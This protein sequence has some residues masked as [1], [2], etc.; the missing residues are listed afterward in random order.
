MSVVNKMLSRLRPDE[1]QATRSHEEA[2]KR[3]E[4]IIAA[5]ERQEPEV[6][7]HSRFALR[8]MAEN[9]LAPRIRR[10]IREA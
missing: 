9:D 6:R 8:I 10:A 5:V 7:Q 4:Q 2:T 3:S 1:E